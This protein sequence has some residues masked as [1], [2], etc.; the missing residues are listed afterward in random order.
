MGT[1]ILDIDPICSDDDVELFASQFSQIIGS[2]T[3]VDVTSIGTKSGHLH[4]EYS[5][6]EVMMMPDIV[7]MVKKA[8]QDGYD[9]AIIG[10]FYDPALRACREVSKYMAITA[11]AEASLHI[12]TT[13]EESISIIVWKAK[14]DSRNQGERAQIRFCSQARLLQ[15]AGNGGPRLSK[16]SR[17]DYESDTP[18]STRS[19]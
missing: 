3:T 18:S 2:H 1:K 8:E 4:L 17:H 9:A 16:R 7:R 13:L 5:C 6:Y 12:A 14:V 10:C 19:H 11:P 15:V